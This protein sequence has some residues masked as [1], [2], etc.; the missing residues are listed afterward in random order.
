MIQFTTMRRGSGLKRSPPELH[1]LLKNYVYVYLDPTTR[2]PFYVG[3]DKGNRAFAHL[4]D[5]TECAKRQM[6]VT[7]HAQKKQPKIDLLCYG[8]T[9]KNTALVEAAAIDL[10]GRPPLF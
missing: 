10:L 8:L 3:R 4:A 2:R 9:D 5:P 7:I 1:A 6:I